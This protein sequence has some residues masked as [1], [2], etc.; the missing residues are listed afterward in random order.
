MPA[1]NARGP[2]SVALRPRA[3]RRATMALML[4]TR[5]A[6]AMTTPRFPLLPLH[7]AKAAADEAAVPDYMAELSIF[8]VLLNHPALAHAVNDLLATMLWH[9]ALD[10]RLRELV[11]MR[12]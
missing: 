12:I 5:N 7:E 4:G 2:G 10:S 3:F 9:G 11:I 6:Q 8:Q 1:R